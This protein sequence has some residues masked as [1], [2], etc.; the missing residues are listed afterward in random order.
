MKRVF[1]LI[2]LLLGAG[3]SGFSQQKRTITGQVAG[4]DGMPIPG[5]AVLIQGTG[6][7][8]ITDENGKYSIQAGS[9]DVLVFSSLGF[10][11]DVQSVNDRKQINVVLVSDTKVLD[12][13]VVIGYGTQKKSDLTG[14]VGIVSMEEILSPATGST[15][16]ALQGRI[17]GVDILSGGGEPGQ[18]TSIRIRGTRSISAGNDPLIVVDGVVDAVESFS[19][20]NPDDIKNITV[21][22]DASSTA[23]YGA[24][25]S[26]GVILV[27]TKGGNTGSK[28]SLTFS[29]SVGMSELPRKL[30]VMNATEFAQF[31]NDY[32]LMSSYGQSTGTQPYHPQNSERYSFEDPSVYGQGTDWQDILTRKALQ[33]EYKMAMNYGDS[34]SHS[35][36]SFGYEKRDGIVIG[37]GMEKYTALLKLDRK[38]FSW[39]KVGFRGNFAI[40]RNDRNSVT[41]NGVGNGSAVCLS[42]LVG[43]T[44]EWNRYSDEGGSGGSVYNSPYLIATQATNYVN[45]K[46]LNL[47]PW[48]EIYPF[49]GATLKS[50][51]SAG[52]TDNDAYSYSPA[53]LPLAKVRKTGGTAA[54]ITDDRTSILSETTLS[55]KKTF[56]KSH[57][58][59]VMGGFTAGRKTTNY[60]YTRGVGYLDDNVGP[61]N[62]GAIM[63]RRNLTERSSLSYIQRLSFL[64]RANYSY[65]SRYHFT[66]T[67]RYDGSSNFAQGHKWGFF[68]AAAFR[69]SI[70]NEP[71]MAG[72]KAN[73][74]T[75]LSL[76]LSAGRSGNDAISSYVSQQALT[77][78]LSTWLFGEN[79]QLSTYPT[80]LDNQSLTWEKTDSYNAGLDVSLLN[81]R[82]TI[83][84]DAFLSNTKDLLLKVQNPKQTGFDSRFDNVGNTRSWGWE[85]AISSRNIATQHFSWRT[86]LTLSHNNSIVT[87]IGAEYEQVATY[88][89]SSQML[90][91]YKV[92]YPVNALWG[93][94][95][96]GVWHNAK[97]R[98]DNETTRT[99]V[100]Y[101]QVDGYAKYADLN[102]DG[103]LD[104][105]DQAYLGSADPIVF[106]GLQN[107]FTIRQFSIGVYFTYS[108]GGYIYNLS[109]FNLGSGI[110]NTNKYRYMM[111]CWHP[112]R[113]P[114]GNLPSAY[115]QDAY[116]SDRYVHDA[117]YLRLK[118]LSVSY[119]FDLSKKVKWAKDLS[120]SAYIDNLFLITGYNGY[121]PDISSS[122]SVRRLDNAAYPNP[123]TYMFSL[124]FRY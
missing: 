16:Q 27:T 65:K 114:E 14:S 90:Y 64:G 12:D 110:N 121:D 122:S 15:D 58:L 42:P 77:S 86:D 25:G 73:G 103:I 45:I 13:A 50:T 18:A 119:T 56:K 36:A 57:N 29:A 30:D 79:Q 117:S 80:R 91:G 17:A 99:W 107:T 76:R 72:A 9:F 108:I 98:E 6:N 24:R 44:D 74:L 54:R 124:K 55:W 43:P 28:V 52:W 3:L 88:T 95:F 11:D 68:P 81:D 53:T 71:W 37:T 49:K 100:S 1:L 61:Y 2:V 35:Y 85:L 115:A 104:Y 32:R 26:N 51:F 70:S 47:A 41:I 10:K 101:Q 113:N 33:Q 20:I 109:E 39:L 19:D 59:E 84:A 48:V 21:L 67:A 38:I 5:A 7:G 87:D 78:E 34:K 4:D 123:R 62:M 63:D 23:I 22:K 111:D 116:R 92:G 75:N 96:G 120:L 93:Y 66:V 60:K 112:V 46:Y 106:G 8:V 118:T 82:V 40:R 31:R 83:T 97:E 105:R 69:W 102:H 94:K 89:N